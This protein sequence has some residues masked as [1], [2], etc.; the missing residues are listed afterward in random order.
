MTFKPH[1]KLIYHRPKMTDGRAAL[2]VLMHQYLKGSLDPFVSPLE[3]HKL[4]YFLQESG[5][6]L[7]LEFEPKPF[8]PY[9]KNLRQVLLKI[10]G[11]FINGYGD[12]NDA[13][14]KPL[15]LKAEA[16]AE[17]VEYLKN[18]VDTQKKMERVAKL[19]EG[20][21]D[22]YGLELLSTVHWVMC[23]TPSANN[24][25]DV[26]VRAVQDWSSRKKSQMKPEHLKRAWNRLKE[27]SW[28]R[29]SQSSA[30]IH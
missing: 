2:V 9:S 26:A 15:E 4:M 22:P 13:P 10:D 3:V 29:E 8:G 17:A 23:H 18:D 11:H 16:V 21:E 27:L 30:Y 1:E 14:T 24:D 25:P 6:S 28:D 7:L 20:F 5:K 19:I 12:G